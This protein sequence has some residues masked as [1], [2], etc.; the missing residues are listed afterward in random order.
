[1]NALFFKGLSYTIFTATVQYTIFTNITEVSPSYPNGNGMESVWTKK[2]GSVYA[3][4]QREKR[5]GLRI[6]RTTSSLHGGRLGGRMATAR[7]ERT[8]AALGCNQLRAQATDDGH[9]QHG[10]SN[11]GSHHRSGAIFFF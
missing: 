4:A 1:M 7:G 11:G 5:F 8:G 6:G 2:E 9:D 3:L 10:K